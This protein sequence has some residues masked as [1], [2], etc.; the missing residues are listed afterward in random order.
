MATG[1]RPSGQSRIEVHPVAPRRLA[2]A[3]VA[4]IR[5]LIV[6]EG[7]EVGTR[8]PSE[9][10]L[11]RM[12]QTS[13]AVVSQALRTLSLMGLVDIRQGSGAYVNRDPQSM[14]TAS[15]NL[16]VDLQEGSLAQLTQLRFWL[17]RLG[18][19]EALAVARPR[20][21][22]LITAAFERLRGSAAEPSSWIAADTVFHAAV[23]GAAGNPYLTSLYES[24]HTAIISI[25]LEPWVRGDGA[26]HWLSSQG[27]ALVDLHAQIHHALRRRDRDLLA[28]ALLEHH[29]V[30]LGHL[31][32]NPEGL[33]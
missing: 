13:R 19:T 23:V 20:D 31:G 11:A 26:P 8:L 3:V 17:E 33:H 32:L 12:F 22:E 5:R 24:V 2:D 27:Q 29:E 21:Q 15:V 28:R 30:L 18:A 9:R 25:E 16:L 1:R 14:V 4:Q 6:D 10:E 7:L